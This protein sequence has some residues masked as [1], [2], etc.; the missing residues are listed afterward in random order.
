MYFLPISVRQDLRFNAQM[1]VYFWKR[2]ML[3]ISNRNDWLYVYIFTNAPLPLNSPEFSVNFDTIHL[4][5]PKC[6]LMHLWFSAHELFS[7]FYHFTKHKDLLLLYNGTCFR[8]ICNLRLSN[9]NCVVQFNLTT[10]FQ[11]VD[12]R[13]DLTSPIWPDLYI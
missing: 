12:P 5:T 8:Q 3:K 10:K 2:K 6:V 9:P 1:N 13:L 4:K 11:M 7:N